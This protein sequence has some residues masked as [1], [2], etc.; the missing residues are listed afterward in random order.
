MHKIISVVFLF[1]FSA[2]AYCQPSDNILFKAFK[3]GRVQEN[4][5]V[6]GNCVSVAII[7]A[8]IA[9]FGF[10]NIFLNVDRDSSKKLTRIILRDGTKLNLTFDEEAMARTRSKFRQS[11][12]ISPEEKDSCDK[13]MDFA[14]FC[15]AVICKNK[16]MQNPSKLTSYNMAIRDVNLSE[17]AS[18]AYKLLGFF[19]E[20][21][22]ADVAT[23]NSTKNLVIYNLK[24]CVF[25]SNGFYDE[26]AIS[27]PIKLADFTTKYGSVAL[28][29]P[30][31]PI[32]GAYVL[33]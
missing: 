20:P 25:A 26:Q 15:F 4:A 16:Q 23:L 3:Q 7:K 32:Y 29:V 8:G 1:L 28:G 13:V 9:T 19:M 31:Y 12:T 5:K 18:E 11:K 27:Q 22:N 17:P 2:G 6:A 14:Q 33:K 21:V 30:K 24:H 10:N